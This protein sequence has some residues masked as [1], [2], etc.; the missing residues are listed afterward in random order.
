MDLEIAFYKSVEV[1]DKMVIKRG[2]RKDL[3]ITDFL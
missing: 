1:S 3:L 2:A